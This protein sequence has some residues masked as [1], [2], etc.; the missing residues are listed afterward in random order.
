MINRCTFLYFIE[1]W[2]YFHTTLLKKYASQYNG[3]NV[4]TGPAFDYNY[5]GQ[6]DSQDQI[7]QY[8]SFSLSY[9]M[10]CYNMEQRGS[11]VSKSHKRQS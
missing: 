3:I 5:D 1:V 10:V 4:V 8:V 2:D 9:K 11:K 7:E 6:F